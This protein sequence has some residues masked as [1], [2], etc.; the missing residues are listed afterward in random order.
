MNGHAQCWPYLTRYD[1]DNLRE[2]AFPLGGIGTGTISL[3]GRAELRDFEIMN[4]PAKGF[5]PPYT[6]FALRTQAEGGQAVTRVLEG[7]LKPPYG[8]AFGVRTALAGLPRLRE[9]R[10]DAAYPLARY[11][12]S[13]PDVPLQIFLEAMNPLVPLHVEA[14]SL[15]VAVLRYVLHNPGDVAVEAS[16]AGSLYNCIGTE[17]GGCCNTGATLTPGALDRLLGGNINEARHGVAGDG[18][19]LQG[20]LMRSMQV[21]PRTPQD[22]TMAL[23]LLGADATYR[24]TWGTTQWNR[25]VLTFWDDFAGDGRLDDPVEVEPSPKGQGQIGS[26]AASAYIAPH[27][28]A[29]FTYLLCWHF[30][31]RTAAGCGWNT[32]A[33]DGGWV[34]NHYASRYEDAWDVA[35]QVA[36][37]LA[38][39]EEQ[40][41]RFAR[42]LVSTSLPQ[43]V[44]EAALNNV[45]TLRSPTCFRTA[46]GN[47]FGFEGTCDG[48]GCCFG[49]CTHVWNYEQTTSSLYPELARNMRVLE[50]EQGTLPDGMNCFRLRLPL[51]SEPWKHAAADGQMGVVMKCYR[52]WQHQGDAGFLARYWPTIRSLIHYA[53]RPGGWDADQDGVMEGVQHNTYDVEFYG[54]NPLSG[55]WYLGAL[56]AATEMARAVGDDDFAARCD[57]LRARGSA[58]IDAHLFNGAYYVQDVRT[59]ERIEDTLPELRAGMGEVDLANPDFQ[60]G[61]GCLVDQ[62]VGQ[63]MAHVVG[64]GH[65]LEAGHVRQALVALYQHNFRENLYDHWNNMR[66]FALADESGLLIGTW[67][68]GGRPQVPFPY[69]GEVMTG[70]EYQA[71][72]H[73]IYEG[74]V[75]EGLNVAHAVRRRFDG[76]RRNPWDEQECGH[77][78]ARAMAAWALVLALSGH[79]YSAVSGELCLHPRWQPEAFRSVWT[80]VSGW[81]TVDQRVEAGR[82]EI[83]WEVQAGS[84]QGL[85]RLSL[86]LPEGAFAQAVVAKIAGLA[87]EASWEVQEGTL[88]LT[89]AQSVTVP[90]RQVLAITI[91]LS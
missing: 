73:M 50:L 34:G 28:T 56:R 2:V 59:P 77:H 76:H 70:F 23:A 17:E 69:F 13:D 7:M 71:A 68:R 51:G 15:P 47:F 25:H 43:Y 12:L 60:L 88:R 87:A 31:H 36:P 67:P 66:T 11:T 57:D 1:G 65:L 29:R 22:G 91:T 48:T 82:Q 46:D 74:L 10:L 27:E 89:F 18:Q 26:L 52:D 79:R 41:V 3:G 21:P 33:D 32:L 44:K 61:E 72:A 86:A 16:I 83:R 38:N 62:L 55:I 49:S 90:E 75:E 58:W 80:T 19:P 78:Y 42:A 35:V 4:T 20:L 53:W 63:Y 64:L 40:T 45:S 54:P 81:G 84:L 39:L 14:S 6:F 30:P 8:G 85:Q 24:R 37:Q 9:V 5:T